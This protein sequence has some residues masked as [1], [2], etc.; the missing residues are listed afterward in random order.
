MTLYVSADQESREALRLL[1][2]SGMAV[3]VVEADMRHI[4]T[5]TLETS[6]DRFSGIRSIRWVLEHLR[7]L[8]KE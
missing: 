8:A 4:Y 2:D 1:K 3:Q 5:P 7:G 6:F